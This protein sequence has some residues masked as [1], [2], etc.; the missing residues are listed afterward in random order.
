[1]KVVP[2]YVDIEDKIVGPLT[3]KQ[4]GW[5]FGGGTILV[6]LWQILDVTAFYTATIPI[7]IMTTLLAFYRPY[8]TSLVSFIGYF[9]LYLFKPR[10]YVWQREPENKKEIKKEPVEMSEI[11][12]NKKDLNTDDIS[13]I[14]RTLD[15]KGAHR[16]EQL[17]EIIKKR[18]NLNN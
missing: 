16:N 18:T 5:F 10:M 14:A 6:V 7:G 17:E 2:Q 1:M 4:L 9:F 11:I 8:G 3:W 13:I 15:T 12:Y